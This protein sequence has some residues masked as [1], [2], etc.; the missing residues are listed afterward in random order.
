MA[1]GVT[2]A[3]AIDEA[4]RDELRPVY[5]V[6]GE[7]HYLADR[8]LAALRRAA[9]KGGV[10]GFNED[11]FTAGE[12]NADKVIAAARTVPMMAKRRLLLVRNVERWEKKG[13]EDDD[14]DDA[15]ASKRSG[16][17]LDQ[18]AEYARAPIDSTVLVLCAAKL[19]A[20]R[21]LVTHAKK[22]GYVVACNPLSDKDLPGFIRELAA[23]KGHKIGSEAAH[24][25]GQLAG[26][27]LGYVADALERLSLF[28][29]EGK[30]ITEDAIANIVTKVRQGTVWELVGAIGQKRLDRALAAL[31]DVFDAR[32][33]G[34]RLLGAIGW[35]VQQ[36]VKLESALGE[37]CSL[38]EAGRRAG[39]PP[40]KT[41]EVAEVVRTTP[42]R[43]LERWMALLA[44]A[45]LALKSSRR[46]AKAILETMLMS[47]GR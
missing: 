29:G 16:S 12:V 17:A 2:P 18:L 46:P 1:V 44:E 40:F 41:R 38:D 39:V 10:P 6:L 35:S 20:Q 28:V 37:G 3:Q 8:V 7:E 5:L 14:D 26:P 27:E 19:H 25:L 22:S 13:D 23:E 30:P 21:K 15:S 45:D 4:S 47:M 32:D 24:M 43:T 11:K 31:D 36:L 34:L 9:M 33:G 42:R